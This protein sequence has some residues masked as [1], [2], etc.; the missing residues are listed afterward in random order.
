M[1]DDR[2]II[3]EKY[4]KIFSKYGWI[5]HTSITDEE[6]LLAIQI[7]ITESVLEAEK[8]L[9]EVYKNKIKYQF[10][11]IISSEPFDIRKEL[12]TFS[13][14]DFCEKRFHSS[15]PLILISIDGTLHEIKNT[16]YQREANDFDI[17][18][19]IAKFDDGY[20]DFV[21]I[22]TKSRRKSN[23]EV[24]SLPFRNGII[25]G[26]DYNYDNQEL[27]V[28]TIALVIYIYDWYQAF[29]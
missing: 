28:K 23:D 6:M 2:E 29:D 16:K 3:S 27:A 15:I 9:I 19:E 14:I 11:S 22:F 24:L 21:R 18:D 4:N 12:F 20:K 1:K 13:Y 8:Y 17:L 10:E 25:H 26:R 5:S 7:S